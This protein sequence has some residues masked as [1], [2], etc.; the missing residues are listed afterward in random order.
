[1]AD[2]KIPIVGLAVEA[3]TRRELVELRRR[4]SGNEDD[5]NVRPAV[6]HLP[7]K[8]QA[9][10]RPWQ[11]DVR[12]EQLHFGIR[13]EDFERLITVG[14]LDRTKTGVSEQADTQGAHEHLVFDDQN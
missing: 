13:A 4:P 6:T 11:V 9:V 12:K 5:A 7:G 8:R 14:G 1:M 3:A 10:D 2:H